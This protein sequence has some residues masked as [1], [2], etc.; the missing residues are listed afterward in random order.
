[1]P[2]VDA[3]DRPEGVTEEDM[4]TLL[5]IRLDGSKRLRTSG[6][7]TIRSSESTFQRSFQRCSIHSKPLLRNNLITP[8]LRPWGFFSSKINTLFIVF[9]HCTVIFSVS[10]MKAMR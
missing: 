2:T 3:I 1:M 9:S 4:K 8:G 10:K 7:T 6:P 5:S